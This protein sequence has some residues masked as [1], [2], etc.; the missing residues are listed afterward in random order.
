[1]SFATEAGKHRDQCCRRVNEAEGFHQNGDRGLVAELSENAR[2][3]EAIPGN[4][5]PQRGTRG[6]KGR[7]P[8]VAF[9]V[10]LWPFP[11]CDVV[12]GL[13]RPHEHR[14]ATLGIRL[15]RSVSCFEI[16]AALRRRGRSNRL[17]RPARP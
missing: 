1:K 11:D 3:R 7:R 17:H 2:S 13:M 6:A 14:T 10:F 4:E 16:M 15:V 5:W 8:F 9:R 12:E